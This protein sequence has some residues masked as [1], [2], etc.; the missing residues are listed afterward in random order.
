MRPHAVSEC[1]V[2]EGVLEGGEHVSDRVDDLERFG[3]LLELGGLGC[4]GGTQLGRELSGAVPGY[5]R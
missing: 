1:H 2:S 3:Y 4:D 5:A